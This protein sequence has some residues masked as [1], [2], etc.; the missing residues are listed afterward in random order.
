[1]DQE[2]SVYEA[3]RKRKKI[4]R[5]VLLIVLVAVLLSVLWFVADRYYFL[6]ETVTFSHSTLYSE[7]ELLQKSEVERGVRLFSVK[8]DAVKKRIEE[9]FPYLVNV[10]VQRALPNTLKITFEE[11]MGEIALRLGR[12]TFAVAADLT[13][14]SRIEADD[15]VPR[16]GVLANGVSRCVVGE[17]IEFFDTMIPDILSHTV[18]ALSEANMLADTKSLDLRDKFDLRMEYQGRFEILLG[19]DEDLGLKLAMVKR[20]IEDQN[21]DDT[22]RIDISDPNDAYVLLFAR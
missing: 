19:E 5:V 17:K 1:M 10:K 16:L 15:P 21:P 9:S 22:G 3:R 4:I 8:K 7:E 12:E 20:V 2:L 6:L 11:N 14:L 13:V 18:T